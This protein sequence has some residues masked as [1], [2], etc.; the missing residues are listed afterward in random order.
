[1]ANPDY[2]NLRQE[3]ESLVTRYELVRVKR[4]L[5]EINFA[6]IPERDL[7]GVASVARRVLKTN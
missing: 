1:M 5:K 3:L 7:A 2:I 6:K 4:I